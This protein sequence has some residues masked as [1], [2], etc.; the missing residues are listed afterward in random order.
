MSHKV[1]APPG[2][3]VIYALC[4]SDQ[5][6]S[7]TLQSTGQDSHDQ[8]GARLS[9]CL[10]QSQNKL[11]SLREAPCQQEGSFLL[12]EGGGHIVCPLLFPEAGNMSAHNAS[13]WR[14]KH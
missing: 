7:K 3:K 11:T 1:T 13:A 9:S 14:L 6:C 5:A 8:G 10:T 4:Y 12:L 2:F